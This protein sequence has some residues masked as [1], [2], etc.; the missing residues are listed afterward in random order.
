[1][2]TQQYGSL[3]SFVCKVRGDRLR[4]P[5][6]R[7]VNGELLYCPSCRGRRDVNLRHFL[8]ECQCTAKCRT[9]A[10]EALRTDDS[11]N[12]QDFC[13]RATITRMLREPHHQ[14][15]TAQQAA[16]ALMGGVDY[17]LQPDT[18]GQTHPVPKEVQ[19]L[20]L[21]VFQSIAENSYKAWRVYKAELYGH[22]LN[23]RP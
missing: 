3:A 22:P 18:N 17:G 8:F 11:F 14:P 15:I 23:K 4:V 13:E 6:R 9:K 5:T 7:W 21:T 12:K 19:Q 1:M 10:E 2:H 20:H 16:V